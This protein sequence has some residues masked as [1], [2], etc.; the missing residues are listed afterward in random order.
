LHTQKHKYH[1]HNRLPIFELFPIVL[2]L[3]LC[4]IFG[5][6]LTISGAYNQSSPAVQAACRVDQSYVRPKCPCIHELLDPQTALQLFLVYLSLCNAVIGSYTKSNT[7]LCLQ[8]FYP[9]IPLNHR[10]SHHTHTPTGDARCTLVQ[11]AL[12]LAV[13]SGDI[14][15]GKHTHNACRGTASNVGGLGWLLCRFVCLHIILAHRNLAMLPTITGLLWPQMATSR[16]TTE[17]HAISLRA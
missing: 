16:N 13:G 2:S 4:W 1:N 5:W 10:V 15:L 9:R 6:I 11:G 3:S 12:P 8:C 14:Q 7:Y 17:A